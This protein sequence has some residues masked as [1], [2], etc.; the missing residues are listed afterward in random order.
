MEIAIPGKIDYF[1]LLSIFNNAR[2]SAKGFPDIEA[3]L[4]EFMAMVDGEVIVTAKMSNKI[5]GFISVWEEENFI[6]HLY[7]HPD[8]QNKGIGPA[9]INSCKEYFGLPLSLKCVEQNTGACDFYQKNGWHAME[10]GRG[11]EGSYIL[12]KLSE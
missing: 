1:V 4:P 6:H 10:R 7:V 9:L 11:P 2:K 12:F 8:Y 3:S 5:A